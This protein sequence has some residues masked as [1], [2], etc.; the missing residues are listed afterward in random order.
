[1]FA[2]L[3]A[4]GREREADVGQ[5]QVGQGEIGR[6]AVVVLIEAGVQP[7]GRLMYVVV[8]QW[9]VVAQLQGISITVVVQSCLE[10]EQFDDLMRVQAGVGMGS[11]GRKHG[12]Q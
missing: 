6:R 1:M 11:S 10:G 7:Q 12:H 3:C 9:M 8:A 5:M 4:F 2:Q